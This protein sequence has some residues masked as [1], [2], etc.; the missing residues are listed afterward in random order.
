V[1]RRE[2]YALYFRNG[3]SPLILDPQSMG[4]LLQNYLLPTINPSP[5]SDF[6]AAPLRPLGPI[7]KQYKSL[8]KIT[9]R[10][11]SLQPQY[12]LAIT[13]AMKDV[14]RW[15]SEAKVAANIV[16]GDLGWEHSASRTVLDS[17]ELDA[18]ERWSL[19][20][21]CSALLEKGALVPLSKK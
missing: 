1:K 2:R 16:A 4:W 5:S 12:K 10:D 13:S 19:E 18:K 8:M 11:V 9:T 21:L 6:H 14:E 15:I 7:L 3:V 20:K 17:G